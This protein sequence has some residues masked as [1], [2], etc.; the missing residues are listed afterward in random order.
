MYRSEGITLNVDWLSQ[1]LGDVVNFIV[2][3]NDQAEAENT[4]PEQ[5]QVDDCPDEANEDEWNEE[6]DDEPINPG[7]Q[8][9]LLMDEEDE[10]VRDENQAIQ[11]ALG[12]GH[13]PIGLLTDQNAEYLTFRKN[14]AGQVPQLPPRTTYAAQVKYEI[15][16]YDRRFASSIEHLLYK[17]QKLTMRKVADA[18]NIALR[19]K[20]QR[21]PVYAHE[22]MDDRTVEGLVQEDHGN[23]FDDCC[24]FILLINFLSQ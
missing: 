2:D 1:H 6:E 14:Y 19:Q 12:E 11:F 13:R 4:G 15:R 7:A 5:M 8:A 3:P 18:I 16:H 10:D 23:Y 17:V 22:L 21:G 24:S 9:T 20:R